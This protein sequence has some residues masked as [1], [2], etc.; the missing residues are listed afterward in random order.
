[1]RSLTFYQ[2]NGKKGTVKIFCLKFLKKSS[3]NRLFY[4]VQE[5]V[6]A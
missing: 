1:M 5:P 4:E 3:E 6:I 2:K